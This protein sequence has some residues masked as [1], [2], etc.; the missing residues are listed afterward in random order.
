M[1]IRV[2]QVAL[3]A[4]LAASGAS[5]QP[6]P[7]TARLDSLEKALAG[8][9]QADSNRVKTL[10]AVVWENRAANPARA[11][12]LSA[13]ALRLGQQ[14]GYLRGQA[15]TYALR[16]ILFSFESKFP[17]A[18]AAYGQ[19]LR[20]RRALGD[21][22][23]VANQYNNLGN[24]YTYLGEYE[25]ATRFFTKALKLDEK[26][27]DAEGYA[28]DL[29]NMGNVMVSIGR[30]RQALAYYQQ[31]VRLDSPKRDAVDRANGLL[32]VGMAYKA[33]HQNRLARQYL[34]QGLAITRQSGD[35]KNEQGALF[36]LAVLAHAESDQALA[37]KLFRQSLT[38]ARRANEP[39]MLSETLIGL[40]Q[41]VEL[42]GRPTE[43]LA[44]ANEG[45]A[46][47]K[48]SGLKTLLRDGYLEA[49]NAYVGLGNYKL[50]HDNLAAH[51]AWRDSVLTEQTA[52]QVSDLQT[53][54]E[55][56]KKEAQNRLQA[57]QLRT[58]QQVI[59]RRNTQLL[60]GLLVA[61]LLAGLAYL[62]YNRRRLRREVEFAQERQQLTQLRAQAVLDAEEAER[63]R[64]GTD[65]HDGVGQ[66]LT[67]AKLNLGA[68]GEQLTISTV[69]QQAMLQNA[70]DVVDE[71]FREVR[72][73]SHNLM[74]NSLIKRGLAQA[75]RDFLSKVSPDGRLKINI[76]VVGLDS[77][78][79]L[80]PNIENVLFRVIQELVQNIIKHARATE[81]TLQ[82]VRS[83]EGLTVLVED[84]GVGFD[85]AALNAETSGIG[86]KN[87][88][89]RLAFLGGRAEFDSR[90]GRGT[91]VTLEVPLGPQFE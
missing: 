6:S 32:N 4:A 10:N 87:I 89:S 35:Q 49:S 29:F 19:C 74:P 46:L 1:K 63:R 85:P 64:I 47:A 71:S 36:N 52:Q 5:A 40:A 50:A 79:R 59:R 61:G 34:T 2:L 43:A 12:A 26:Y 44:L 45:L 73:I 83:P 27:A 57:A 24:V 58:Q 65:L 30:P 13:E 62:L 77:G 51:I 31:Y 81:M 76:E 25:R 72:Q 53:K 21:S 20:I 84:N 14:L 38:L 82:L 70:L 39:I 22:L 8:H 3:A 16:G 56:E 88:E 7:A 11:K 69:A 48:A 17:E 80:E 18:I 66:L 37:E 54:Y 23:G 90:P 91:T 60:A 86:L 28:M 9:P 42:Q 55:T 78:G 68:L 33:L 41:A 15:K 75:V 67:V